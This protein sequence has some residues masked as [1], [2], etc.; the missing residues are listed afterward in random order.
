MIIAVSNQKG[1]VAKT[2]TC[3]ALGAT[4]AGSGSRVLIIDCDAQA[5]LTM[6]LGIDVNDVQQ[7][8]SQL[9][10]DPYC[11]IHNIIRDTGYFDGRLHIVPAELDLAVVEKQLHNQPNFEL[12]LQRQLDRLEQPY[13]YVFCD[14]PPSLGVLTLNALSA[15]D[16]VIIPIACEYYAV[17][18]LNQIL[19]IVDLVRRNTN[20]MLQYRLLV[21]MHDKRLRMSELVY[22][23]VKANFES[24]LFDTCIGIDCKIKESQAEGIPINQYAPHTRAAVQYELLAG[25]I[26]SFAAPV[27][28]V[29]IG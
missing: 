6:G 28:P 2:T 27:E 14:C 4:L 1:G 26:A 3:L 19:S 10:L 21:T 5:N 13:D 12:L 20:A 25:E 9:Y 23:Q 8:H 11:D 29:T 24:A 7:S 22:S 17:G 16:L 15:A 18:G